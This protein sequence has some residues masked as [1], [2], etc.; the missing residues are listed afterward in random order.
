MDYIAV[1]DFAVI[2][3]KRYWQEDSEIVTPY[4]VSP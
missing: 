3:G 2:S 4:Y 1:S